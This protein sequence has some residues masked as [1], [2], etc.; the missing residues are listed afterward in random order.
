MTLQFDRTERRRVRFEKYLEC[1]RDNM[2]YEDSRSYE[3]R[4]Y[5]FEVIQ[6]YIERE[7]MYNEEKDQTEVD[8]FWGLDLYQRKLHE[9]EERL[10]KIYIAKVSGELFVLKRVFFCLSSGGL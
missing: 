8:R 5:E 6:E 7:E 9:E 2:V 10:R 3:L 4:R 1:E